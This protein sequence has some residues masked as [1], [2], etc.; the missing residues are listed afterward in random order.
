MAIAAGGFAAMTGFALPAL[1]QGSG[2]LGGPQPMQSET[3]G[4]GTGRTTTG[5]GTNMGE[6]PPGR[7]A[8]GATG[9]RTTGTAGSNTRSPQDQRDSGGSGSTDAPVGAGGTS[10]R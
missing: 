9:Q 6:P 3:G 2:V 4:Q 1:A 8:P 5:G 10:M 7:S